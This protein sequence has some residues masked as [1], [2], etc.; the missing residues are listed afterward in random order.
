MKLDQESSV[1]SDGL[2][3]PEAPSTA[4]M[5]L[6][7]SVSSSFVEFK[8][9]L[10]DVKLLT[11]PP[12]GAVLDGVPGGGGCCSLSSSTLLE[13]V[14]VALEIAEFMREKPSLKDF[15]ELGDIQVEATAV[16]LRLLNLEFWPFMVTM[17]LSEAK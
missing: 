15:L 12:T 13:I 9:G 4:V 14:E 6:V 8:L 5:E 17:D 3:C 10:E 1:N 16:A 2:L 11:P 7:L